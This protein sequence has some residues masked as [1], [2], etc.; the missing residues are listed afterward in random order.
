MGYLQQLIG[1][2][3]NA[4]N[5]NAVEIPQN[6][7]TAVRDEAVGEAKAAKIPGEE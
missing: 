4:F 6:P 1:H 7:L 2:P 5:V 3:L